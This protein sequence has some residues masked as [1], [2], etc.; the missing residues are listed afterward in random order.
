MST[1]SPSMFKSASVTSAA[2]SIRASSFKSSPV[3]SQSTQTRRSLV[4]IV[5]FPRLSSFIMPA[6]PSRSVPGDPLDQ[7]CRARPGEQPHGDRSCCQGRQCGHH[8]DHQRAGRIAEDRCTLS[9]LRET[10]CDLVPAKRQRPR[11]K[12]TPDEMPLPR[13]ISAATKPTL[14]APLVS[15]NKQ[16]AEPEHDHGRHG[17]VHP[18]V[19]VHDR[20]A[21]IEQQHV[22]TG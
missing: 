4:A 15:G 17:D 16:E 8:A 18:S 9:S 5:R 2:T 7:P 20:S 11:V 12:T 6:V 3:I 14:V 21:R 13:P 1:P 10:G 19:A 22:D